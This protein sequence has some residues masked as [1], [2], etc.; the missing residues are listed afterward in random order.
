MRYSRCFALLITLSFAALGFILLSGMQAPTVFA[1]EV[2]TQP[3]SQPPV[4]ASYQMRLPFVAAWTQSLP[5]TGRWLGP[6]GGSVVALAVDPTDPNIVYAGSYGGGVFKSVDGGEHWYWASVGMLNQQIISLSIDP[7]E[8]STLYAGTQGGGVY[9][10]ENGGRSW[11]AVNQGI[12]AGAVVYMLA[13][14]PGNHKIVY[15]GT[16]GPMTTGTFEGVLYRSTDGGAQWQAVLSNIGGPSRQDWIY[17]IAVHPYSPNYVLATSHQNGPFLATNYGGPGDWSQTWTGRMEPDGRAVAF[18]PRPGSMTAYYA[19]WHRKGF[20]RSGNFGLSWVESAAGLDE[21]KVYPNGI[22]IVPDRPNTIFLA[23]FGAASDGTYVRGVMKSTDGGASWR[24]SGLENS[25]IYSVLAP[26]GGQG[27]VFAGTQYDGL[28]K[29]TDDGR[30]WRPVIDG[31][32]NTQVF[33]LAFSPDGILYARTNDGIRKSADKG[34]T[35]TA[36]DSMPAGIDFTGGSWAVPQLPSGSTGEGE[37]I[38]IQEINRDLDPF[39]RIEPM[40]E[41]IGLDLET[42][43]LSSLPT[44]DRNGYIRSTAVDPGSPDLRYAVVD[45]SLRVSF[46]RGNTWSDRSIPD[47]VTYTAAVDPRGE[48]TVYAGTDSGVWRYQNGEWSE[49]GLAGKPVAVL[50]FSPFDDGVLYAGTTTGAYF[51]RPGQD[52]AAVDTQ[53]AP[54]TVLSIAFDLTDRDSVY[55]GTQS[56]GIFRAGR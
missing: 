44:G 30:S 49:A 39:L 55:F 3:A 42:A 7:V 48:H 12:Q 10:T 9:K 15:A 23:T 24:R 40:D 56:R 46:D 1:Q 27:I 36:A 21:S 2:P 51:L 19:T 18:D 11:T 41:L 52:W 53:P 54:Y 5:T 22:G 8:P 6:D 14:N 31:L 50:A 47:R 45:G 25:R 37:R 13:V 34:L 33:E 32:A 17:S 29:S 28:F 20:Y 4:A 43:G 38:S 35:W 16:R 26:A